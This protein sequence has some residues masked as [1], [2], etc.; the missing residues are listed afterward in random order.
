MRGL[1]IVSRIYLSLAAIATA[2][3]WFFPWVQVR[4]GI[5]GGMN[6]TAM[7][8][9][10]FILPTVTAAI[11]GNNYVGVFTTIVALFIVIGVIGRFL[12]PELGEKGELAQ[13]AAAMQ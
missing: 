9:G 8:L 11:M 10:M 12:M 7:G 5:A 13:K 1:R 2:V 4:E 3:L 6:N